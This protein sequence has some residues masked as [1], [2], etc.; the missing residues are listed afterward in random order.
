MK[1][2]V[3]LLAIPVVALVLGMTACDT[4][5]GSSVT[6]SSAG[7]SVSYSGIGGGS[8]YILTITENA[9]R[10]ASYTA[11]AGDAY[12]LQ[13]I[14]LSDSKAQT[15]SGTVKT[16]GATLTLTPSGSTTTFTVT[17]SGDSISAISG[18]ITLD[19]K[20]TKKAPVSVSSTTSDSNLNGTWI[21]DASPD[22]KYIFKNGNFERFSFTKGTYITGSSGGNNYIIGIVI[23][24]Y[25]NNKWYSKDD[26]MNLMAAEY[27]KDPSAYSWWDSL[28]DYLASYE[29]EFYFTAQYSIS[30]NTLT[31]TQWSDETFTKQ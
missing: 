18:T 15:S 7:H 10:A 21:S 16:A 24:R 1:S 8:A 27:R 25:E 4:D 19:D 28:D 5:G 26:F 22:Y 20:K 17:V 13:I 9:G 2:K 11:K 31:L 30:G 23:Q 3:I 12:V 6:V 14:A 29:Q